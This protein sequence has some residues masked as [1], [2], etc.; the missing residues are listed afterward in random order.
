MCVPVFL[1]NG[2]WVVMGGIKKGA[3]ILFLSLFVLDLKSGSG[4][5][6]KCSLMCNFW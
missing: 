5:V 4:S 3:Y 2:V 1:R 6:F